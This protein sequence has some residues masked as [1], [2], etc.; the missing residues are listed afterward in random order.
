M[1]VDIP[2]NQDGTVDRVEPGQPD[3]SY[4]IHKLE[5]T[6]LQQ[7]MPPGAPLPQTEIDVIR[8]WIFDGAIDDRVVVLAPITVTSVSPAPNAALTAPPA[9]IVAGFSRDL[10]Q[11]TLDGTTFLL[12]GSGGDGD[13]TDGDEVA[14]VGVVSIGANPASAVM[15]LSGVQLNDDTYRISLLGNATS[16]ILDLDGNMLDG[17][18][19]GVFPSG[20]GAAGGDFNVQFTL[21]TPIVIGPTLPQIQAVVFT[22]TC[23]TSNCHTGATPAGGLDLTDAGISHAALFNVASN[24]D[25]AILRVAPGLPDNSYLVQKLEGSAGGAQMPLGGAPLDPAEIAAIRLWITNGALP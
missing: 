18:Y 2:S 23:A 7:Q 20:N 14:I 12:T 22:P 16:S 13:F 21:T 17:E 4:L 8:Q 5:G 3:N 15:D 9:N 6:G 10:N 1:L 11:T 25:P 19:L 24:G